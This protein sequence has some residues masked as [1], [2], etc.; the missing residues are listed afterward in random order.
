MSHDLNG[1]EGG[2]QPKLGY[3]KKEGKIGSFDLVQGCRR[4]TG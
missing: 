1:R 2:F 3:A 4:T